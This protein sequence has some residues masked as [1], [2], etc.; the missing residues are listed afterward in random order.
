[1]NIAI[2]S[3]TQIDSLPKTCKA[4]VLYEYG[5]DLRVES[6]PTPQPVYGAVVVKIEASPV[7]GPWKQ[8]LASKASIFS[9]PTPFV[10]GGAA[11]ARVVAVGPDTTT[12]EPGQLVLTDYFVRARDNP[13]GVQFLRGAST[14]GNPR[15]KKLALDLQHNGTW[16][17]YQV[18]AHEN[19]HPLD[20]KRFLG[21]PADGGLGYTVPQLST[22]VFQSI[23]YSGLCDI[24]LKAGETI[25]ILPA[26]GVFGGCAVEVASA[27]GARIVAGGR[28]VK[29]LK[30]LAG[31]V[32]NVKTVQLTGEVE[33]DTAAITEC[34]GPVDTYFDISAPAMPN[35]NHISAGL[36]SLTTYGRACMMGGQRTDI[37]INYG[38]C[39]LKSLTI[40]GRFMYEREH[41]RALINL[42]TTGALKLGSSEVTE[43]KLEDWKQA[44]D[45]AEDTHG[46]GKVVCLSL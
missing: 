9:Y 44:L 43:F 4:A 39:V 2:M 11:V 35:T 12:L 45:V 41:V 40:K 31:T 25:V 16:A 20:E 6:I 37:P 29:A 13:D 7:Y 28:N 17:E 38:F 14:M 22:M 10:P 32:A 1:M 24:G 8:S 36:A 26:T 21:S 27:M 18:V 30:K 33:A 34:Y 23:C 46:W 3:S 5:Q 19:C 15:A 42:A